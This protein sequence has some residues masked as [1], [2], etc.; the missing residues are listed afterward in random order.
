DLYSREGAVNIEGYEMLKGLQGVRTHEHHE[1]LP[2]IKNSQDI[3]ALANTVGDTLN[4]YSA[5]H[6]FLL[7]RHGL[8][9]WGDDLA[10]AKRHIEILEFLLETVGRT[11]LAKNRGL[12]VWP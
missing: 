11:L 9:S 6:G 1:W 8:Y 3:P 7:E 4:N 12:K 10:Q 5:I 2:I